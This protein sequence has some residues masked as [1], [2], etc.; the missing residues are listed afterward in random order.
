MDRTSKRNNQAFTGVNTRV[1]SAFVFSALCTAAQAAPD[2]TAQ[3]PAT[4]HQ[5]QV[6]GH[7]GTLDNDRDGRLSSA[8]WEQYRTFAGSGN[9]PA[10]ADGSG[11]TLGELKSVDTNADGYV[12]YSELYAAEHPDEPRP[13]VN[14]SSMKEV[15]ANAS[16]SGLDRDG[17]NRVSLAEA[18]QGAMLDMDD[19]AAYDYH[20]A[21]QD[22]DGNLSDA[23]FR[24]FHEAVGRRLT[25]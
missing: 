20:A 15:F 6:L 16:F 12:N 7:F 21:D 8:E 1:V 25:E 22:G 23:E 5:A 4:P 9:Q 19:R 24:A 18:A 10:A 11:M 17:D 13:S 14:P 2:N 3:M